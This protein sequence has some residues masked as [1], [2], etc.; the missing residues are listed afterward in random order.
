LW[1]HEPAGIGD[2]Q[3]FNVVEDPGEM[4]DLSDQNPEK[5]KEL[6]AAWDAYVEQFNVI[7]ANRH[8]FEQMAK[9][10]PARG[11]PQTEEF[12]V[13]VGPLAEQY[14]QLVEMYAEQARQYYSWRR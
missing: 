3:L 13:L 14:R 8:A 5:K 2:W 7:P 10:L 6:L 12:P 4:R 11:N 9:Q 1:L